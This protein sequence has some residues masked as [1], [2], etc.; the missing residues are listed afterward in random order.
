[1]IQICK[2]FIIYLVGIS[3][4]LNPL[5][6]LV[7][8]KVSAATTTPAANV[9]TPLIG[10]RDQESFGY[11]PKAAG[12]QCDAIRKTRPEAYNS[13]V[14]ML[15]NF[16]GVGS[17]ALSFNDI[18]T[19]PGEARILL[20]LKDRK[21]VKSLLCLS[22]VIPNYAEDTKALYDA[23]PASE[24][25]NID[26]AV[27]LEANN[28]FPIYRT[29]DEYFLFLRYGYE[30][31]D[32]NEKLA[33]FDYVTGL[34]KTAE[35]NF[36][37]KELKRIWSEQADRIAKGLD[38]TI[39]ANTLSCVTGLDRNELR[40]RI[41]TT[42]G[43][44]Y[45]AERINDAVNSLIIDIRVVNTLIYLVTP[46]DKGGAGHWRVSVARILQGS[47]KS[48]ESD[49]A[50]EE[51]ARMETPTLRSA[52][53]GSA[54]QIECD[55]NMTAAECGAQQNQG[56]AVV[57]DK[58]GTQYEAFFE[59][60]DNELDDERNVSA[61]F[62]GQAVDI[63]QI[64][65]IRCTLVKKRRIG[66]SSKQKQ[67]IR[68]IKL[69][70]QTT[71]GW[72]QARGENDFDTMSMMR[73]LAKQS[74]I[75]LLS[76][77]NEDITDYDGDLSRASFDD[78]IGILGQS[79]LA[80]IVDSPSHNLKGYSVTNTIEQLGAMY[81]A[82]YL[83][84]PREIFKNEDLKDLEKIKYIIGRAAIE[85]RLGL[86]FGS[87]DS[88][89]LIETTRNG[90]EKPIYNLEGLVLNIGQR[91]IEYEMGFEA[92]DLDPYFKINTVQGEYLLDYK[93]IGR[94]VIENELNL[95]KGSWPKTAISFAT[96]KDYI[97]EVRANVLKV[98]PGYIDSILH[99]DPGTTQSFIL[100][101]ITSEQL[102]EKVGTVR[103][104]NTT[105]GLKY[106]AMNNVAYQLPGP[107]V[108]DPDVPDTW[109]EAL[110][111]NPEY[112]KVIGIYTLARLL[113]ENS[114][115]I[116]LSYVDGG[117]LKK[118]VPDDATLGKVVVSTKFNEEK[119]IVYDRKEYGFF[120]FREWIRRNLDERLKAADGCS[121]GRTTGGINVSATYQGQTVYNGP[122]DLNN[123]TREDI[124]NTIDS[125]CKLK[126]TIIVNEIN[127]T[128]KDG[129]D[130][131]IKN[132]VAD[133]YISDAKAIEIG[134]EK[135]DLYS[136][137]GFREADA[138]PVFKRIGAKL[139]Y[140][141]IANKVLNEEERLKI[142]LMDVNPTINVDEN[143]NDV[144]AFYIPRI[145]KVQ[146]LTRKLKTDWEAVRTNDAE[147]Q[148]ITD[149]ISKIF[150]RLESIYSES[151]VNLLKIQRVAQAIK[152][153]MV[154]INAIKEELEILRER[155]NTR[156]G[157]E[158]VNKIAQINALIYNT[159]ELI[160]IVAEIFSGKQINSS[161]LLNI[162][163]ISLGAD[164]S[165]VSDADGRRTRSGLS[166]WEM[167][168]LLFS[169]LSGEISVQE[170]IIRLG[171]NTAEA[172]LGLPANSLIYLVQNFDK[173]G[174]H[175]VDAFYQA[176]GQARIEEEFAMPMY[177]F[178]GY[179]YNKKLPKFDKL[180]DKDE[181]A[182]LI[183]WAVNEK[184]ES[185][186]K[187]E[188][189]LHVAELREAWIT[190]EV[191]M[192]KF[193]FGQKWV[194]WEK[195]DSWVELAKTRWLEK[196]KVKA[197]DMA[198]FE[199]T[200]DDVVTN[201]GNKGYGDGFR[202][203]EDDLLF[204]MGL[205]TGKYSALKDA[206]P[207]AWQVANS[208]SQTIDA[209][210]D[211]PVNSTK[212]LFTG[213][214]EITSKSLSNKEKNLLEASDL[215]ISKN[216]IEKYIQM[217]NGDL[218]PG[219]N[220]EYN[221]G[222]DP[223]YVSNNPYADPA[224]TGPICPI[225]FTSEDGFMV[226]NTT[227]P[228]NSFCY[229]DKTGRHCFQ[230]W[231][232][233]QLYANEHPD[234]KITDIL[235]DLAVKITTAYNQ[236]LIAADGSST[237]T[238][239]SY[240][241]VFSGLTDFVNDKK[242][243]S[244]FN[245]T[246]LNTIARNDGGEVSGQNNASRL[247]L[248]KIAFENIS[249]NSTVPV[250]IF[251]NIFTR[252]SIEAPLSAYKTKVGTTEAQKILTTKIFDSLNLEI[253]PEMFDGSDLYDILTGDY[254]S[255]YRLGTSYMDRAL[256]L[257]QGTI[258][259]IWTARTPEARKCA[260]DKA[261]G[262]LLG[263]VFGLD[264]LPLDR[265]TTD[266]GD[267]MTSLG[268]EK[269]EE[270]LSLP[271]GTFRVDDQTTKN[272]LDNL[273]KNVG[274]INFVSVF[275]LPIN[276][277]DE[278]DRATFEDSVY[279]IL[280]QDGFNRVSN[281][282]PQYQLQK[283]KEFLS[284]T[285]VLTNNANV[286]RRS[287]E[288]LL[289]ELMQGPGG[290]LALIASTDPAAS[291]IKTK[292]ENIN[293]ETSLA[294]SLY[295]LQV[296][297]F[298]AQLNYIDGL[299]GLSHYSTYLMLGGKT[300]PVAYI[301]KVGDSLGIKI[302]GLKLAEMLGLDAM[303]S[304]AA[305]AI[306]TNI[307]Q[308]FVCEGN[309]RRLVNINGRQVC[310]TGTG[311][312]PESD[313][314]YH[315]WGLIY[316]NLDKIFHFKLDE[317]AGLP[318]GTI[319]KLIDDPKATFPVL[320]EIGAQKL[321]AKMFPDDPERSSKT[322]SFSG[323]Y[324]ALFPETLAP[325]QAEC[326][327]EAFPGGV[328]MELDNKMALANEQLKTIEREYETL[329]LPA[330]DNNSTDWLNSLSATDR[331]KYDAWKARKDA[332][333][334]EIRTI[335]NEYNTR[336]KAEQ[337]CLR[338][339]QETSAALGSL[340]EVPRDQWDVYGARA[341][342][343]AQAAI[344]EIIHD[345]L[346]NIYVSLPG[347]DSTVHSPMGDYQNPE[348]CKVNVGIDMPTSDIR[349]MMGGDLR[350]LMAV[351]LA[352]G[353]NL[354]YILIDN[355]SSTNCNPDER[356]SEGCR[357]PVPAEMRISYADIM[358]A[359]FGLPQNELNALAAWR[360]VTNQSGNVYE[361]DPDNHSWNG[362]SCQ[363]GEVFDGIMCVAS[364]GTNTDSAGGVRQETA[365]NYGY[366]PENVEAEKARIEASI[367]E[368][369]Q[370]AIDA[371]N[372]LGYEDPEAYDNCVNNIDGYLNESNL[373]NLDMLNHPEKYNF[374]P[375]NNAAAKE[376]N[377][378]AKEIARTRLQYKL[379]DTAL[380]KLDE[381]IFPGF[382]RA[383]MKGNTG[384]KWAALAR[385][386]KNGLINGHLFGIR[387]DSI[388]PEII[389][390]GLA[391]AA[392]LTARTQEQRDIA[393]ENF[394]NQK[395]NTLVQF[396]SNNS[397]K[398]LGIRL[399]LD[400]TE[401]LLTSIFTGNWGAN[402][403]SLDGIMG[404]TGA[405]E[406]FAGQ[407]RWTLG[408]AV[409]NWG[410]GRIF[411]WADKAL[412]LEAGQ[413]LQIFNLAKNA[414]K[415]Y[416]AYQAASATL[417]AANKL[418]AATKQLVELTKGTIFEGTA[419]ALNDTAQAAQK[420]AEAQKAA[421][422]AGYGAAVGAVIQFAIG[423]LVDKLLGKQIGQWEEALGLVPG[424]LAPVISAGIYTLALPAMNAAIYAAAPSLGS[425][426]LPALGP[427]GWAAIIGIF[428]IM[429]LFGVYRVEYW[430]TA[431]GYFPKLGQP[432]YLENDI[433]PY[434]VWGGRVNGSLNDI[435]KNMS[436]K[437]AQYKAQRLIGDMLEMQ[438]NSDF[439]DYNGMPTVPTQIMTGREEDVEYWKNVVETNVCQQ[440]LGDRAHLIFDGKNAVCDAGMRRMG[441]WFNPQTT[442][443]THIGF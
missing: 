331:A 183:Q 302:A 224:I 212:M 254:S 59:N 226:N 327:A 429:N 103:Y 144:T 351:T 352:M 432:N 109:K 273:I 159:N 86:P 117:T 49:A 42:T 439:N 232:E 98:D 191:T 20:P 198:V 166:R 16:S 65:D 96:L 34:V 148:D 175:G 173:M 92:H 338:T 129:N 431:D 77:M 193:I 164:S 116:D 11:A 368:N 269:I 293:S 56:Q 95:P 422:L 189:D 415:A 186:I 375:N 120:V 184:G 251:M 153:I 36:S 53:E 47:E 441:L 317:K 389:D 171:A 125:V 82:D 84:L 261:G 281:T 17:S 225:D 262:V 160:R 38:T 176:I 134:L 334:A 21:A 341:W 426:F 413:S 244:A 142:N 217:L 282:S 19:A 412:G 430:C 81:F 280:G 227:L 304:E 372:E 179:D 104:N 234:A 127:Y 220:N 112:I 324:R 343:W 218:L 278:G 215:K 332:K 39:E 197:R 113:G 306:A 414:Y 270:A 108:E 167:I 246:A 374:D 55:E 237:G 397:E 231:E 410:L 266:M 309:G 402:S 403:F 128:D 361:E 274:I 194:N 383:I 67:P 163:Q 195:F 326:H 379:M 110:K 323:L 284:S 149:R 136:I 395:F 308:I 239:I 8:E 147:T 311:M 76:S 60:M 154:D 349:K 423:L 85:K 7:P 68:P 122:V 15:Q 443:W 409:V 365:N 319:Q 277:I 382:S 106:F 400:I 335:Q 255:L 40:A 121:E 3:L 202:S 78:L 258:N 177:Y 51:N 363:P 356:D 392:Y 2:N 54:T 276:L 344:A 201:I 131:Q 32:P 31:Q 170:F 290:I 287:L 336:A 203:P 297:N 172:K 358:L 252:E 307:R 143:S 133:A 66:G 214:E 208:R 438:Y 50:I 435:I 168:I 48:R 29:R 388:D 333:L 257:K 45:I 90:L 241:D 236:S 204:R 321:D 359:L 433:S 436:I 192:T 205:P 350:Y 18:L 88:L 235:E 238:R 329:G 428:I 228:A 87:L 69:V 4:S 26:G 151:D 300:A 342:E 43:G 162:K 64:D 437:V 272:N 152:E 355:I 221:N 97:S 387:F 156:T 188:Y 72:S 52:S 57:E 424:T 71:D 265:L 200:I 271:R 377:D 268:Q 279:N 91:K 283:V 187:P 70:W 211:V 339:R 285:L 124:Q 61:H 25:S 247:E 27:S 418:A 312:S 267:F 360:E 182:D 378:S 178:Q 10:I 396:I 242:K 373:Q 421:K 213:S 292:P 75:D 393:I 115:D 199:K 105:A 427:W 216:E 12:A 94:I 260:L 384:E 139:L 298:Y 348:A 310:L 150:A 407:E 58:D 303:E 41:G 391:V 107:T 404:D 275:K 248:S 390:A 46:K 345:K 123:P 111:G 408:G 161:D 386:V 291:L 93:S 23:L 322:A 406:T 249:K 190:D 367:A 420:A 416:K 362:E 219:E 399:D 318:I 44:Q 337:D 137:M 381:N 353:A 79:L 385:Y 30:G 83:E 398:W 138:R 245:D 442:A 100:G 315:N 73:D 240:I 174:I 330:G 299:L 440:R 101:R 419:I 13:L 14:S 263:E 24:K 376:I 296:Q 209:A 301:N 425:S 196:N 180:N 340:G 222:L 146:E 132:V 155:Y 33:N 305:L 259:L 165:G 206:S 99:I 394:T 145:L 114:L 223:D 357:A 370:A 37:E 288:A 6:V 229:Y 89:N 102:A 366:S 157:T 250:D 233:A 1:M 256:D 325:I 347:C 286:G 434:G 313:G 62:T 346:L 417:E 314:W 411:S 130:H 364:A 126:Q 5:V 80:Q 354:A 316:D 253:D 35:K 207:L 140:Y 295:N 63:K 169:F 264:Y 210:F 380:W 158:V 135:M 320:L 28:P 181:F 9:A 369:H 74:I 119:E 118:Y 294:Y 185:V 405:R 371:C 243:V 328:D 141:G 230:S 22:Q 401:G 289:A